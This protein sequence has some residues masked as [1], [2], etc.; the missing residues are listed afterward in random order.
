V[1]GD[2]DYVQVVSARDVDDDD[3]LMQ[4]LITANANVKRFRTRVALDT[5]KRGLA[6]PLDALPA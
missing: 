6:V 3:A 1:T 5:L 2:G 4:R